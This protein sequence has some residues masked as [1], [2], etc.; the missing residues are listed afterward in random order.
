M[1]TYHYSAANAQGKI[2]KGKLTAANE[3]DLE[4]RLH[5]Q[6]LDMVNF[7]LL[8]AGG[9]KFFGSVKPRDLIMLCIHLEQLDRAGV[10]LLDSI[11]DLRDTADSPYLRDLMADI[12]ENV[13]SGEMLSEAMKHYPNIFSD[14]FTGLVAA[15]EKTGNLAESFRNL[16]EHL[17][18]TSELRRKVKKAIRYP[19]ALLI[20]MSGVISLM[21]IYVVPQLS[22]FLLS[23]G[24]TLPFYTQ[25]LI[26]FSGAFVNYWYLIFG[27]PIAAIIGL[28]IVARTSPHVRHIIDNILLKSPFIGHVVLKTNLARFTR[29]FSVTFNSGIDV[30]ECLQ[31]AKKVVNNAIIRDAITDIEKSVSEGNSITRAVQQTGQFPSL[32]VRMFKVGE[33][34]GDMENALK[35]VNFFY[36]RE[37]ND[38]VENMVGIIQPALTIVMGLLMLWVTAAVFGPLYDSLSK[39]EF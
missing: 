31:T 2:V 33:D 38:A 7:K 16:G 3:L 21:M 36:D 8:K 20:L 14:V 35:N 17:K 9:G 5:T 15:G 39:M 26:A 32:V 11:A 28:V 23:Q 1:P 30:L 29:F 4:E 22:E 27:L 12:Y 6:G 10:P 34:S 19:I 13:K 37:V 18:W 24:F 25:A